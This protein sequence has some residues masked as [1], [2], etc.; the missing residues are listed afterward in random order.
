MA[1]VQKRVARIATLPLLALRG[2]V[3]F[4]QTTVQFE[5]GR[6]QSIAA[7]QAAMANEQS[8]FLVTQRDMEQEEP[9]TDDLCKT[10]V[11]VNIR[12][13]F[14]LPNDSFRISVE[15]QYRARVRTVT[16]TEPVCMVDVREV[17]S[18]PIIDHLTVAAYRR[19]CQTNFQRYAELSGEISDDKY[20]LMM[21]AD[22][23]GALVDR[24]AD[25]LPASTEDKQTIL[26]T[27]SVEKRAQ[28]LLRLL[29]A[30]IDI[31]ELEHG[32][33]KRVQNAIDKNQRDYYL[34]E[35]MKAIASE[36]GEEDDPLGEAE[37]LRGTIR[38]RQLP[39]MVEQKLL[40][41]CDKLAKM[42]FG[43][44]EATVVRLYLDTC[45]SLP[46]GQYSRERLDLAAARRILERDHYGLKTV[47]E[48]ILELLAVRCLTGGTKGQVI[49]LV[50]PPGVGKTSIAKSIA[51]ALGR[52][53]VRVS[54]GGVRDEAEIRGHRR[55]YIGSK[56]GRIMEALI[57]AKTSN[58]LILLDE[59]DKLASGPNG[60]PS[61]ALLEVL[62]TEQNALFRDHYVELPYDLSQVLFITTA[63]DAQ[64][65]PAPLYDRMDVITISSYT[66][67]EKFHIAR[68]HLIKKQWKLNG[69]TG[70][71]LRITDDAVRALIDGYT[72]EGGVRTLERR[73]AALCRKCAQKLVAGEVKSVTVHPEQLEDYLGARR[74]KEDTAMSAD[75]VGVVN[76]L[77]WT[78]VGGETMPIEVA[79]M[80]GTG[81]VELTG[82]LGDV[83]KE[84]ARTAITYVRSRADRWHI[85][86]DFYKT[87][88]IHIHV[89]EGA[90]PKDGP[91]AG[92]TMATAMVSALTGIP[93]RHDVAMTGEISLRG[94]V[95]PIGGLKEK[96]MAAYRHHFTTVV[97]PK[98]NEPDLAELD[99][100]V[101]GKLRFVAA[102]TMDTV[103]ETALNTPQ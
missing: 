87:K 86:S 5:V 82:S 8:L 16:S 88:D 10:G 95:L 46:W 91:S 49:C 17:L 1:I 45:L 85:N 58:P 61:S 25:A 20:R 97:I 78:A 39:E 66:A 62:D 27:V 47:K 72:R 53:Y 76:G 52:T 81:K 42:P 83:M 50:G 23:V 55:T 89:P 36:L 84:S 96:S 13:I 14:R 92:V 28:A 40:K 75:E 41:E 33:E 73:L 80:D 7:L 29:E 68:E 15:A 34:H 4:P 60:D 98:A 12:Q 32:I 59:I 77:A 18:R 19:L 2:L 35:Q 3:V 30:E 31:L 101:R 11:V 94:R 51:E 74:Y 48:R 103:I 93:V 69:L 38:S 102:Q 71:Q 22:T 57:Q 56:P 70:R 37:E 63:N 9:A 21:T 26:D 43:S 64:N 99:D 65:I 67:E 6:P 79:V 44:H 90:V 24:I 100:V 54:L